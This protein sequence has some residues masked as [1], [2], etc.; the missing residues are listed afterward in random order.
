MFQKFLQFDGPTEW[1]ATAGEERE[2]NEGFG[3]FEDR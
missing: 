1:K 3:P 2:G